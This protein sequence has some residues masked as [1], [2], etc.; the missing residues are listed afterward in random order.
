MSP[1]KSN[2]TVG[3][4][5]LG[6]MGGS[7]SRNLVAAGWR[8]VGFD[9]D[10][11]KRRELAKAGVEIVGGA[12]A[13]AAAAPIIITSLPKP[14]ALIATAKA[15]AAAGLPR[16]IIAE[17]STFT[18][19]DKEKAEKSAARRRPRHARLPGER[20]RL[21]GQDRRSRDLRQRRPQGG[22]AR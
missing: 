9:I 4:I 11:G 2:K 19:E 16:R 15:I 21:A 18:I 10:A 20:H 5:G 6:I 17:C 8:V 14:E 3:V 22:R 13:V 12:K 7:F 1:K